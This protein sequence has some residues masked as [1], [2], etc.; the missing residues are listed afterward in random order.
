MKLFMRWL[1]F[2]LVGAMGMAVQ[3]GALACF[4]RAMPGHYLIASAAALEITLLHNVTWHLRYTWRDRRD[5]SS[6]L[7]QVARFHL[8]N[9][10]VSM[11]GNLIL[12]RLFV[13]SMHLPVVIANAIAI[14]CCSL[15]NFAIGHRWAFAR[16]GDVAQTS[17]APPCVPDGSRST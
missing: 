16:R 10:A 7:A 2:N 8:A 6:A 13:Q 17:A 4:T 3:L 1:R 12:M 15:A 11:A 9:G 5:E 14:L